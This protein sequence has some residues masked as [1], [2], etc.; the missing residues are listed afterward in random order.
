LDKPTGDGTLYCRLSWRRVPGGV[1]VAEFRGPHAC[2]SLVLPDRIVQARMDSKLTLAGCDTEANEF[3]ATIGERPQTGRRQG[4]VALRQ[5]CFA[6]PDHNAA[7]GLLNSLVLESYLARRV[8]RRAIRSIEKIYETVVRRVC[9]LHGEIALAKT[10]LVRKKKYDEGEAWT[11]S[12]RQ[13][14]HWL[15]AAEYSATSSIRSMK[16]AQCAGTLAARGRIQRDGARG[17]NVAWN[18]QRL[19]AAEYSATLER[20][21]TRIATTRFS[22]T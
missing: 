13:R 17:E 14:E 22:S 8:S 3:L 21:M 16:M 12:Q 1:L 2:E 10:D 4:V 11:V 7:R 9:S 15:R 20:P 18:L 19:R 5:Y 6:N